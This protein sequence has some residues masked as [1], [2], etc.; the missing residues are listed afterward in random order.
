MKRKSHTYTNAISTIADLPRRRC[1]DCQ[2]PTRWRAQ[3]PTEQDRFAKFQST[4]HFPIPV[5]L[6]IG[7]SLCALV[8]THLNT[9]A[10]TQEKV[11][12]SCKK[13]AVVSPQRCY[14]VVRT[15]ETVCCKFS[16]SFKKIF[17]LLACYAAVFFQS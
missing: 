13:S 11:L 6:L 1:A 16:R 15:H 17:L 9:V 4:F 3:C 8:F 2:H 14:N 5:A 7:N 10:R 12:K